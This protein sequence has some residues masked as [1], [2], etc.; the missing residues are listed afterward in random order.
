MVALKIVPLRFQFLLYVARSSS[1]YHSTV[2][3]GTVSFSRMETT[4]LGVEIEEREVADI[5]SVINGNFL[6]F[7]SCEVVSGCER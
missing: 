2:S 4:V 7:G 5:L 3:R 1:M 6:A